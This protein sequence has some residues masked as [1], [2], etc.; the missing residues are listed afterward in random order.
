M[1]YYKIESGKKRQL[2]KIFTPQKWEVHVA[3]F[4]PKNGFQV[5][6]QTQEHGTHGLRMQTW[7]IPLGV[8]SL[9]AFQ[10]YVIFWGKFCH[11]KNYWAGGGSISAFYS[12]KL[13]IMET[14]IHNTLLHRG[15]C[16]LTPTFWFQ[17]FGNCDNAFAS[18]TSFSLPTLLLSV[19]ICQSHSF[20]SSI[21]PI[22][23]IDLCFLVKS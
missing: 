5:K 11:F 22:V 16:D 15:S 6:F 13:C 19:V 17:M 9:S 4:R 12:V 7:Q 23:S 3:N 14:R 21:F 18:L 1:G 20:L 10:R 2:L 8:K